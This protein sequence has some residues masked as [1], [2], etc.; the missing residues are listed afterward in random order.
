M[1]LLVAI[2]IIFYSI[3]RPLK[4]T[5]KATKSDRI[6]AEKIIKKYSNSPEDFFK[7][8]P[9]DKHYYFYQDSLVAFAVDNGIAVVLD[10][11]IGNS[12]IIQDCRRS[13]VDFC[14]INGWRISIIH[15]DKLEAESWEK[16]GL[17]SIVIGSEALIDINNFMTEQIKNKHFRYVKNKAAKDGLS[18]DYISK[19]IKTETINKLRDISKQWLS[20]DRRE[21]KFIMAP[22]NTE[23][24]K[25]CDVAVLKQNEKIV[26]YVNI[27][28]TYD[29]DWRSIDHMRFASG[30]SGV[31]MHYLIL[32]L[33]INLNE[34]N[35]KIL[36]L[37]LAPLSKIDNQPQSIVKYILRTLKQL[38]N[39][40]YSFSGVEQFKGKFAP[41]WSNRYITYSGGSRTLITLARALTNIS[42]VT[43][44]NSYPK[45][46]MPAV[47]ISAL[48]YSSFILAPLL[49]GQYFING[50]VSALGQRG[51]PYSWLFN[52][53]DIISGLLLSIVLFWVL[54][55]KKTDSKLLLISTWALLINSIGIVLAALIPLPTDFQSESH[56]TLLMIE[57]PFVISHGIGSFVNS[58]GLFTAALCYLIYCKQ[59]KH[60]SFKTL[61]AIVI[62]FVATFGFIIGY[63]LKSS[64]PTLQR[65]YII[66]SSLFVYLLI[67]YLVSNKP[68]NPL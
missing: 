4:L 54:K 8:Y 33:I 51:Q 43:T 35:V 20:R 67:Y 5:S 31:A 15:C 1:S 45:W 17:K 36:N 16:L 58:A 3:L 42:S 11:A 13:F 55:H 12:N 49:N 23:Y 37:G 6:E 57:N 19:P 56:L 21:Y 39:R 53:L 68:K 7:T 32:Q 50:L 63:S 28:P 60:F 41:Q 59:I 34:N 46:I 38:G 47:G 14:Q 25:N 64:G 61:L 30:T 44:K 66:S 18:V 24:I 65:I 2:I 40:Y 62:L 27:I 48:L 9:Q 29:D 10:G 52:I 26:A 22:F